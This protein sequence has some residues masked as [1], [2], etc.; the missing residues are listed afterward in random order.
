VGTDLFHIFA[1]AIMGSVLHR[2]LGNISVSLAGTFLVGSIA[3]ATLG[4]MLNRYLYDLNPVLSDL[5]ITT[6]YVFILG[7]LSFYAL[8]DYFKAR[9]GE[10]GAEKSSG[11]AEAVPPMGKRLQS[12]HIPPMLTFD[13]VSPLVAVK[14]R[15]YF[16]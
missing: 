6:V 7:F 13:E 2:K 5:F 9:K 15:R 16:S 14:F 10:T 4:G 8:M 1:K 3:G 12:I 11:R